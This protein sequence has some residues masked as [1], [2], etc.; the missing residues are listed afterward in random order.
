MTL[1]DKSKSQE[2]AKFVKSDIQIL[3]QTDWQTDTQQ[4]RQIEGQFDRPL[5]TVRNRDIV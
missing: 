4:E 2:R 1:I 3:R 5:Q